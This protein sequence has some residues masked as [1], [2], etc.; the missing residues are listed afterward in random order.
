MYRVRQDSDQDRTR[1]KIAKVVRQAVRLHY[2][3]GADDKI[4][5]LLPDILEQ[6][7]I[8]VSEGKPFALDLSKL[9]LPMLGESE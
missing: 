6:H 4:N 3:L 5:E 2:S 1:K 9:N 8:A 7:A